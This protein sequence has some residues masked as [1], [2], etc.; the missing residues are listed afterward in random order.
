MSTS[1]GIVILGVGRWGVHLVRIFQ[2]H[3]Q[4]K[5]IAIVDPS[6][7]R[8][9]YCQEQ[10]L[11][12]NH[13][14]IMAKDWQSVRS[15]PGIEAVAIVTP[16][17]VHYPLILDALQLGYHVFVEKPLT[18]N[19]D[20]CWQLTKLAEEKQRQLFVD[21]TYLFN[22]AVEEGEKIVKNRE[23]GELRYGYAARTHLGPIRQDVDVLWDLAI[24]DLAIFNHWLGETPIQVQ[25]QGTIWL[26]PGLAD[27]VWARLIYPSSF[28]AD[29]HFCWLN[30]DKQ[31]RLAVVG[32]QGTLVFDEMSG[33]SP[34]TFYRGHCQQQQEKFIPIANER[35]V[36]K[37]KAREPLQGVC[38]RFINDIIRQSF[39][40]LASGYLATNLVQT[41]CCL[42]ASLVAG[43]KIIDVPSLNQ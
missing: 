30:P 21:H 14:V 1:I 31:R 43:G 18:L 20:E 29:L 38:D 5:I 10:L 42:Q 23:L 7:A 8:L 32:T 37:I 27:V 35:Q 33:A 3:P 9:S 16:A 40:E 15:L 12:V 2:Q 25:A 26:Q 34:L 19:P 13:Q 28:Q 11:P 41:L 24:H 36:I 17:S 22:S 6:T 4:A 39:S